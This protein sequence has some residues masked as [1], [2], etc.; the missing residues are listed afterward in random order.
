MTGRA[1]VLKLRL[2]GFEGRGKR[3]RSRVEG[4]RGEK[5]VFVSSLVFF[6]V[7]VVFTG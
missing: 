1:S 2:F 4:E 3:E 6:M 7:F 5:V